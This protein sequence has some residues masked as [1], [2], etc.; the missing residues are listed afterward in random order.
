M[1]FVE[2][3]VRTGYSFVNHGQGARKGHKRKK[4]P[5][6]RGGGGNDGED[7]DDDGDDAPEFNGD[8]E[9]DD[10]DRFEELEAEL[11]KDQ[12]E[13]AAFFATLPSSQSFDFK[14]AAASKRHKRTKAGDNADEDPDAMYTKSGF[15]KDHRAVMKDM[16]VFLDQ[17]YRN[18]KLNSKAPLSAPEGGVTEAKSDDS[19]VTTEAEVS[20]PKALKQTAIPIKGISM[21][22]SMTNPVTQIQIHADHAFYL[23]LPTTTQADQMREYQCN[24][25]KLVE[26]G[27]FLDANPFRGKIFNL[28]RNSTGQLNAFNIRKGSHGMIYSKY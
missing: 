21:G 12:E 8:D 19:I 5:S 23:G 27:R 28:F 17:F 2:Q 10:D 18:K 3:P 16:M 13:E 26:Q 15:V 4:G 7:D 9:E 25:V 6:S 1:P 11:E 24:A 14:V 22:N 20:F